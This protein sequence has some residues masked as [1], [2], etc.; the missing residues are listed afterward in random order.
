MSF[1]IE[2]GNDPKTWTVVIGASLVDE[3]GQIL[4]AP[5]W[6]VYYATYRILFLIELCLFL[7]INKWNNNL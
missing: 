4:V 7:N 5:P 1:D 2:I 3:T 6:I